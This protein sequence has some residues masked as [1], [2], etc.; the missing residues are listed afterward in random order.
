[1]FAGDGAVAFGKPPFT[2]DHGERDHRLVALGRGSARQGD[3]GPS[4]PAERPRGSQV[5]RSPGRKRTSRSSPARAAT[6]S[7]GG[8][9]PVS[10]LVVA[11]LITF[12]TGAARRRASPFH[13]TPLPELTSARTSWTS[14]THAQISSWLW[15]CS[16]PPERHRGR[17]R[18]LVRLASRARPGWASSCQGRA[19]RAVRWGALGALD[20][21]AADTNAAQDSIAGGDFACSTECSLRELSRQQRRRQSCCTGR[22]SQLHSRDRGDIRPRDPRGAESQRRRP[23]R[24]SS[25][26]PAP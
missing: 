2:P 5:P 3:P 12:D 23:P 6:A 25:Q 10:L 20:R 16:P 26:S 17:S 14:C 8:P 22:E 11:G 7:C 15:Q 4:Q 1:M 24:T 21:V 9:Y 19:S 18:A 13:R